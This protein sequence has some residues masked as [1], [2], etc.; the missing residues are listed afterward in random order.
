MMLYEGWQGYVRMEGVT[1]LDETSQRATTLGWFGVYAP[2]TPGE[3]LYFDTSTELTVAPPQF[4]RYSQHDYQRR[5]SKRTIDWT[6]EQH[7][8]WGW[9][10]ARVPT[11]FMLRRSERRL[12]RILI[13]SGADQ[14]PTIVNGLKGYIKSLWLADANGQVYSASDLSAGAEAKL[15]PATLPGPAPAKLSGNTAS[16]RRAYEGDWLRLVIQISEHPEEYLRPGCY[17]AVLA[18]TPFLEN[19]YRSGLPRESR[20]VVFG[21]MKEP[22]H[23]N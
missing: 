10:S 7:L 21:I 8:A 23:A 20:S 17:I 13:R 2:L 1:I 3:G 22:L 18:E 4:S 6:S 9:V 19:G 14:T 5:Q 12:E 15:Q 11:Y 16:L